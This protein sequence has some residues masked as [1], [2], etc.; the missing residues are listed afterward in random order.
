MWK[1]RRLPSLATW[2]MVC[3]GFVLLG[4]GLP[5]EFG[6]ETA[7]GADTILLQG[8]GATF[9][10][11]L[12]Q[13]WFTEYNKQHPNVQVNYQALG[14]G[15]GV[16]QFQLH[17]VD[18]GAS[19]AAMTDREMGSV[20]EGVVLLPMTAG[21][22]VL[23]YNV[24]DVTTD[25]KLSRDAYVGIFLGKITSWNDPVIANA[26]PGVKLPATKITVV[27]RSDGSGTTFVFTSHLS[28]ISDEWKN[29]PGAGK[30]VNFPVGLGGKGNPGVTAL[31]KQ[32]PGAIGYV[33]YGYA[34]YAK[35]PMAIL[36]NKSGKY[37]KADLNTGK[38]ALASVQL[39]ENLRGWVTDPTSP[40]SYP[41]V[42]YTWLLCYKK[43]QNPKTLDALKS[44]LKYSLTE[45]QSFSA[46]LG[47]IPL[48]ASVIDADMKALEQIS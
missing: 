36:E 16:K 42:T 28:A 44:V 20:K 40:D 33:E 13:K 15:A 6:L 39:P 2:V 22:I 23:T 26:N 31:I 32:T 37:V 8:T 14:S 12:Y 45:G 1:V 24:P 11:P 38:E 19:D 30:S 17:L 29:G 34:V 5:G 10:A 41:I 25:L 9:P 43:Y 27:R 35:M 7:S 3:L 18:F 46:D 47:Y 4:N 48:P 21:S